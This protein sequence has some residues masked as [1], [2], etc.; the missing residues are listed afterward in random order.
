M[1]PGLCLKN[2]SYYRRFKVK[3]D[4]RWKDQYVPVPAPTDPRFAVE[5]ERV[6]AK[7]E[8]RK[9]AGDGTVAALV[10]LRR[11]ALAGE[12]MA[13]ATRRNWTYYLELIEAEHGHR[14]VADLRRAHVY[15]IR[16]KM[17]EHPGK[18]N[19]YISKLR[20][21]LA[22]ACE[23][24]W[25]TAN[26]A[27]KVPPLK[28]GE[29]APWPLEVQEAVLAAADPMLRLAVVSGLCSGQRVG[30]VIRM[31]HNWHDGQ[32]MQFA[33]GKTKKHVA[34]PM[35]PLWLA[36]IAKVERCAVTL[37]YDRFGKPFSGPDRIQ[38]RLRRLMHALGF[39]DEDGQLLYTFHG[40]RKNACCYLLELGLSDTEAGAILGMTPETVRHYG[41]TA[42]VL[43]IA[44]GAADRVLAGRIGG[45]VGKA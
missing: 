13:A 42:R 19:N 29:H 23:R 24:D 14:L 38:E 16:D 4:G 28:T 41:K 34:I 20:A 44:Q 10:A 32:V 3:V 43:N 5:W 11:V 17:A 36:E 6:N 40:L 37:L 33:Q 45:L 39:V 1:I 12:T 21:L 7:P 25:I 15:K 35:H 27:E 8:L 2:G 22:F 31:H 30:D 26:P 9:A 18:A